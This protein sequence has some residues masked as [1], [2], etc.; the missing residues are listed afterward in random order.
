MGLFKGLNEG[1]STVL[2][3]NVYGFVPI[4]CKGMRNKMDCDLARVDEC[5]K[6]TGCNYVCYGGNVCKETFDSCDQLY[7]H[8]RQNYE[9]DKVL[10]CKS[11]NKVTRMSEIVGQVSTSIKEC[12]GKDAVIV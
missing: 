2:Y 4:T 6:S 8:L 11:C 9:C 1:I 5:P 3:N 7:M 12:K 10:K